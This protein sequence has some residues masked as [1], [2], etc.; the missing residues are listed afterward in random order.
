MDEAIIAHTVN[1]PT[2]YGNVHAMRQ[3]VHGSLQAG[4]RS[5]VQASRPDSEVTMATAVAA[6]LDDPA[7]ARPA[8]R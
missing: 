1:R 6:H 3:A 5:M 8:D 2:S 4:R 7:D